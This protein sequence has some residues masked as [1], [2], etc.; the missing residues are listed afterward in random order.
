MV[1]ASAGAVVQGRVLRHLQAFFPLCIK[2]GTVQVYFQS[3]YMH[4]NSIFQVFACSFCLH[5]ICFF[6]LHMDI[7]IPTTCAMQV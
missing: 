6:P 3:V 1:G 7:E 2:S 5:F 4:K